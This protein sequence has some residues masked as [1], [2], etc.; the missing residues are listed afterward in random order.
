MR[1]GGGEASPRRG[2]GRL[3][4]RRGAR[5][6]RRAGRLRADQERQLLKFIAGSRVHG[7]ISPMLKRIFA[8]NFRAL[9]NFELRPNHLSLLLGGNGSGKTSVFDVLGS[10]RDLIV[11]GA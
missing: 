5:G 1:P 10:L 6:H 9:V 7:T 2:G 3:L 11:L 8:D 4:A